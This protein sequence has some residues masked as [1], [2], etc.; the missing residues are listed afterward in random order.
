MCKFIFKVPLPADAIISALA[1]KNIHDTLSCKIDTEQSTIQFSDINSS[2]KYFYAI[3]SSE[4]YSIFYLSH[5]AWIGSR[6]TIPY[7]INPFI[8]SKLNAE[9]VPYA[10]YADLFMNK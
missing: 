7:K 3:H 10:Q 8:I 4:G 5:T 1:T 9:P 2:R 6:S